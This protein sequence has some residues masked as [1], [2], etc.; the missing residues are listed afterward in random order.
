MKKRIRKKKHLA[1]FKELG[2]PVAIKRN[3]ESNF[4]TFLDEF[5]EQSIEGNE[6]YFGG[7]GNDDHLEGF[8]EL[9]KATDNPE[10]KLKKISEWLD[11]R[12]DIEK[13]VTGDF[14]DAWYGPFDELDTIGNKIHLKDINSQST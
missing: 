9:G 2:V 8:I 12:L 5:L 14:V 13:Y 3:Q 11:S 6:C 7:G 10:E 4:D 1:E